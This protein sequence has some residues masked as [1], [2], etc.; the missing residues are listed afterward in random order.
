[1]DFRSDYQL[2]SVPIS[3]KHPGAQTIVLEYSSIIFLV[4]KNPM[5][6]KAQIKILSRIEGIIHCVPNK[7]LLKLIGGNCSPKTFDFKIEEG[8]PLGPI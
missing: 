6:T 5:K 8:C 3:A 2:I 1:L 4:D 7:Y